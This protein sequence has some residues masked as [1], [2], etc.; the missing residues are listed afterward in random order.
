MYEHAWKQQVIGAKQ[1]LRHSFRDMH[2][3]L[4]SH[5]KV[6]KEAGVFKKWLLVC[7]NKQGTCKKQQ[8]QMSA[9]PRLL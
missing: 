3:G 6:S 5:S 8:P 4:G 2:S 7:S 1:K 9:N